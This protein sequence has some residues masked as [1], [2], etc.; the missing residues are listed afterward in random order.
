MVP[1]M[2]H[3]EVLPVSPDAFKEGDLDTYAAHVLQGFFQ[4]A[5]VSADQ[6]HLLNY[7]QLP[8][9]VWTEILEAYGIRHTPEQYAALQQRPAFH[10]KNGSLSFRGDPATPES[11]R[12]RTLSLLPSLQS[13]YQQLELIR[14]G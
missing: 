14:Q 13:S 11:L 8:D 12:Q 5:L 4:T 6:L 10:S 3:P 1:H 2:L 9:V 7:H